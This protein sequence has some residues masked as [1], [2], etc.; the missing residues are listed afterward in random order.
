MTSG[1]PILAQLPTKTESGHILP[2]M[3]QPIQVEFS[4][5]CNS[6]DWCIHMGSILN[7]GFNI[8]ISEKKLKNHE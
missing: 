7:T 6:C 8:N 3:G 2:F 4:F 1:A 5:S